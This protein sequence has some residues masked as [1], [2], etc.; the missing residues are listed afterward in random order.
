M[1]EY[2]LQHVPKVDLALDG[3]CAQAIGVNLPVAAINLAQR[4]DKWDAVSSRMAAVGLNKLIKVPA[5]DGSNLSL[6]TIAPLLGQPL[7]LIEA[8][9]TS[10][11]T[12]TRPAIGC[13]LSHLAVWRWML[14]RQ[15]PRLL[16]FEDDANPAA[17]FD[18]ARFTRVVANLPQSAQMVFFGRSI[19]NG[20]AEIPQRSDL[21][22]LYF[23]N[24]TF[25]YLITPAACRFLIS[26]LLPING[27]IDHEISKVFVACRE[28]FT[29]YSVEPPL[30]EPDWSLRSDCYVPLEAETDADRALGA[31]LTERRNLLVEDGRP[32]LPAYV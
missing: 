15:L 5:V 22:R 6:G 27:H 11:F 8:P 16:I 13:F 23:F 2:R 17:N 9:P 1:T 21:A 10:H 28:E 32:L 24:G 26:K 20:M 3:D 18:P 29:A 31:L 19:M 14:D 7:E 4:A 25:A 12:L 30:F